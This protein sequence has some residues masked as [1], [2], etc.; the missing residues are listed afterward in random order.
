M[1]YH[2][3]CND[4]IS[5]QV[6]CITRET[7]EAAR[8]GNNTFLFVHRDLHLRSQVEKEPHYAQ[9]GPL[10]FISIVLYFYWGI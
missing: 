6:G 4:T 9:Y 8:N 5:V 3:F 1:A 10:F 7:K 2:L